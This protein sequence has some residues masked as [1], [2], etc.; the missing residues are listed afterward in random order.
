MKS[1]SKA[2]PDFISKNDFK[3]H[4]RDSFCISGAQ[5]LLIGVDARSPNRVHVEHTLSHDSASFSFSTPNE[6]DDLSML[7]FREASGTLMLGSSAGAVHE[8]YIDFE[9]QMA[10]FKNT[11]ANLTAFP[12][13]SGAF[14]ESFFLVGGRRGAIRIIDLDN[15][16]ISHSALES[17]F[18]TI[19]ALELACLQKGASADENKVILAVSG[20]QPLGPD[21]A[22]FAFDFTPFC[23][24]HSIRVEH[25]S[26]GGGAH[27]ASQIL[28]GVKPV[29]A[30]SKHKS[31]KIFE[32]GEDQIGKGLHDRDALLRRIS[33]LSS[34]LKKQRASHEHKISQLQSKHSELLVENEFLK[35][36]EFSLANRLE[37]EK[38]ALASKTKILKSCTIQNNNQINQISRLS[39]ELEE[40]RRVCKDAFAKVDKPRSAKKPRSKRLGRGE[41]ENH[42]PKAQNMA[43]SKRLQQMSNSDVHFKKEL[44][45]MRVGSDRPAEAR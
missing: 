39:S 31:H 2:L 35:K 19:C 25:L 9:C 7:C 29:S 42:R 38:K 14:A 23:A 37:K 10:V 27:V 6:Q 4:F 20:T 16:T 28:S 22:S 40:L 5:S 3:C 33:A 12:L 44:E 15:A 24:Q 45:S 36:R 8:Y 41:L 1:G 43:R 18:D 11:Y 34:Q 21:S 17:N 32:R 13:Y 26:R 30:M